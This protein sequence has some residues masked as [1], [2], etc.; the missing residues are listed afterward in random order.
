VLAAPAAASLLGLGL[1]SAAV[2]PL[3]PSAATALAWLNGW[4]AAYLVGVARIIGGLPF[5]QIQSTRTLLLLLSGALFVTA[6][7]S[8]RWEW[9]K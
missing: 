3:S 8:R 1:A 9:V 7:A 5:A 2:A 4:C 6:Y